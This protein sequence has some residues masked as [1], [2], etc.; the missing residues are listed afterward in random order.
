[1]TTETQAKPATAREKY[2]ARWAEFARAEGVKFATP[3]AER[4]YSARVLMFK[5]VVELRKPGRVPVCP[6]IG[7][8][9]FAYAGVTAEQA[10]YDYPKMAMAQQ[11]Y[12]ADFLPDSLAASPSTAAAGRSISSTTS[13]TAGP[14]AACRRQPRTSASS[15]ST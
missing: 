1:M 7:F 14:A 6:N 10:M 8:Y 5:D 12:H 11:K 2:E 3:E 9:P 13:S 4:H 15:R